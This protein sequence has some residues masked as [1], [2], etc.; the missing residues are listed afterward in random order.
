MI[1]CWVALALVLPMTVPSLTEMAQRHPVAI[2]PADAPSA[3]AA[4][5][6]TKAFG[7]AGSENVLIV[8]LTDDKG[9]GPP[10]EN[11][12]RGLVDRLRR[13]TRDV[14]M[15]QDFLS[16]PPLHDVLASKDGKAWILPVGLSGELGT[17]ESYRAYTNVVGMVNDTVK[18]NDGAPTLKATMTGPAA[19]VADMTD[20]GAHD[21][22][23]IELAITILLLVILAV[24]YR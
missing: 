14:V 11:V 12:Y 17:P 20:A 13:D 8:L 22:V 24:I 18:R 6:I 23:S 19:T 15:L 4:K 16:T 1:G 21:R 3:V 10:D 9:L 2:L 7:Q 5:K